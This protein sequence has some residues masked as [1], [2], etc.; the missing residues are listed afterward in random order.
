M[1]ASTSKLVPKPFQTYIIGVLLAVAVFGLLTQL[2]PSGLV[3]AAIFLL[4]LL[5]L[6]AFNFRLSLTV[7]IISLFVDMNVVYLIKISNILSVQLLISYV[8]THRTSAQDGEPLPTMK[9][10]AVFF[11]SLLPSLI[12]AA[13]PGISVLMLFNLLFLL[14]IQ[15]ALYHHIDDYAAFK[16]III[17]YFAINI[18]NT[19]Y[20]VYLVL[21][22]GYGRT[23]G[24]SGIMF[25]D[26][27]AIAIFIVL[28]FLIYGDKNQKP[29]LVFVL[30][31]LVIG[32]LL[33]QTRNPMLN[34]LI[35]IG[36]L[37]VY[38]IKRGDII[39]V[40][41]K[42]LILGLLT[43]T[44]I[45]VLLIGLLNVIG[46]EVFSRLER[47]TDVDEK[48]LIEQGVTTNSL[49]TRF[50]IWQ[51][52]W[53]AFSAH[54]VIG[55]GAFGFPFVS[56]QYS[57]LP[58]LIYNRYV[59]T[60]TPHVGYYAV[61]I[62]AGIIGL[63]A[64]LFYVGTLLRIAFRAIKMAVTREEVLYSLLLGFLQ[65]YIALSL[66]FSDAWL[67]GLGLVLWGILT[68]MMAANYKILKRR[69]LDLNRQ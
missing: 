19:F 56:E 62:E 51:I 15:Y 45:A 50:F 29:L 16:K 2:P 59:K 27:A 38:M 7:L 10:F 65:L 5:A 61:L 68:G 11:V 24:F 18:V 25:G 69:S 9:S 53:E 13:S 67:W 1:S 55:V 43:V 28:L 32:L 36:L 44:I 22:K 42:N 39:L 41:R 14:A 48:E 49:L 37:V 58:E 30:S 60:L 20:Q 52:G 54:P 8:I 63:I 57:Q 3:Y 35:V 34:L 23:F 46:L 6:M 64:F 31:V 17:T 21:G 47:S 40:K 12:N 26:Y 66:L 33:S 4:P